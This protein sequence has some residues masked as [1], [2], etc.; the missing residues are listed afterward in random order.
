MLCCSFMGWIK[1]RN[2]GCRKTTA[3]WGKVQREGNVT[4]GKPK[5]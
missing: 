5:R 1:E 3:K 2:S 4:K